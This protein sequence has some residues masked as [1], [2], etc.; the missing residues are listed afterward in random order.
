MTKQYKIKVLTYKE[1]TL[2]IHASNLDDAEDQATLELKKKMESKEIF[3][4]EFLDSYVFNDDREPEY[5]DA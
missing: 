2:N 5:H 4:F 3:D 1:V